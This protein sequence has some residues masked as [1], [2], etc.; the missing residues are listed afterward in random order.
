[1]QPNP[2]YKQISISSENE[3]EQE[4][5]IALLSNIGFDSFQQEAHLL[6]GFVAIETFDEA[7][8]NSTLNLVNDKLGY[9]IED[10]PNINWN[11]E[12]E[13]NFQPILIADKIYVKAP[14]HAPNEKVD[15]TIIIDPKMSFGTGHHATTRLMLEEMLGINFENKN[16][17]D[18]GCGTAI[19]AIFASKLKAKKIIALDYEEW[20]YKNA[21]ENIATNKA[22]N[23]D[24]LNGKIELIENQ[25]F[26]VILAN[27]NRNVL[28]DSLNKL[29]LFAQSNANILLSG[30]MLKDKEVMLDACKA[31]GWEQI[32][33]KKEKDWLL[34]HFK[35]QNKH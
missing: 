12:W 10:L 13:K 26:D 18:Y 14:F 34:L 27:I 35:T 2:K 15:H 17:F 7:T 11:K 19:L 24:L 25:T 22:S 5:L 28:L 16:I 8:L 29:T 30:I 1:M 23:I 33:I 20:A 31:Q 21:L 9:S 32:K 6:K 4:I 3:E